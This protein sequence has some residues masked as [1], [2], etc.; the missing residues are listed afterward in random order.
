MTEAFVGT[1]KWDYARVSAK[2]PRSAISRT[3]LRTARSMC[4]KDVSSVR[5][6]P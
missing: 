4:I 1:L 2:L 6:A 5:L 3:K